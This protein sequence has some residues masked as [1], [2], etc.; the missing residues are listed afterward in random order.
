M[1]LVLGWPCALQN[2]CVACSLCCCSSSSC[3]RRWET[4]SLCLHFNSCNQNCHALLRTW[5]EYSSR[6][7]QREAAS[8]QTV[9]KPLANSYFTS[10]EP[11]RSAACVCGRNFAGRIQSKLRHTHAHTRCVYLTFW[12]KVCKFSILRAQQCK[13]SFSCGN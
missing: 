12:F 9:N 8:Y 10:A 3:C 4:S 11:I 13:A 1:T 2:D 7:R 6:P 5:G